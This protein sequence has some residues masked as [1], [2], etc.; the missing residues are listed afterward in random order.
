[1]QYPHA[2]IFQGGNTE[3]K[4][5]KDDKIIEATESNT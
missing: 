3:D 1:M 4:N 5:K 2:A